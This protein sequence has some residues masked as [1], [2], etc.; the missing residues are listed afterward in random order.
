MRTART[1]TLVAAGALAVAACTT[2]TTPAERQHEFG[3]AAGTVSGAVVGGVLGSLVG[4][5]T[6]Q[7]I[8]TGAGAALGGYAGS[9]L[10][11]G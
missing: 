11:C 8:A 5:V 1:L 4:G 9:R 10:A 3:C 7:L 2:S 6:G